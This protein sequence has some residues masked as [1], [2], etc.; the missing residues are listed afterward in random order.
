[1]AH[2]LSLQLIKN[3]FLYTASCVC[4]RIITA[5]ALP[6]V[7]L[8]L[9]PETFG[10]LTLCTSFVTFLS[11]IISFGLHKTLW[12]NYVHHTPQQQKI[13]V[14]HVILLY[15]C[16][17]AI[18]FIVLILSTYWALTYNFL[19]HFS[20]L[21]ISICFI[22]SIL[23]FFAE[24]TYQVLRYHGNITTLI[25]TQLI[26]SVFSIITIFY[27]AFYTSGTI[28]AYIIS[29]NVIYIPACVIGIY[30]YST[31]NYTQCITMPT[32]NIVAD[33]LKTGLLFIP[34]LLASWLL[35]AS[36][37]FILAYVA[38]LE[39][40]TVF[41][42]GTFCIQLFDLALLL[43][44]QHIYLP[45]LFKKY[46]ETDSILSIEY[47]NKKIM[48]G[49]F[50]ALGSFVVIAYSLLPLFNRLL[51]PLYYKILICSLIAF[52][53]CIFLLGSH[54]LSALPHYSKKHTYV[55]I[56]W[57]LASIMQISLSILLSSYYAAYGAV[58]SLT[59]AYAL[60]FILL[61]LYNYYLVNQLTYKQVQAI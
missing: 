55:T 45:I 7:F 24:L 18:A 16:L 2:I 10:V 46:K 60:H 1:M 41:T 3:F 22:S 48:L 11:I 49:L 5:L 28:N 36:S 35:V 37:R 9:T 34:S 54:F 26:G 27:V 20:Y 21:L 59:A 40:V 23:S 12:F 31:Q 42:L 52:I 47:T 58:L 32:F 29:F 14:N 57:I 30:N 15:S 6:L 33:Y 8:R 51:S 56:S 38:T 17:A 53:G 50:V 43:P 44:V 39:D 19:P 61:G 13:A 25:I 4:T